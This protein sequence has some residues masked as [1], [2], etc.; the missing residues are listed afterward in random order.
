MNRLPNLTGK[1][2]LVVGAVSCDISAIPADYVIAASGGIKNAPRADMLVSIDNSMRHVP[3]ADADFTGLRVIGIPS[4]DPAHLY[5]PL[6]YEEVRLD[7]RTVVHVRNNALSAIRLAAQCGA[8]KIMLAGFDLAA[9]DSYNAVV[10]F[11][12]VMVTA[13][14]ALIAEMSARGVTVEYFMAPAPTKRSKTWPMST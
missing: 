7:E 3:G 6:P 13:M 2:V 10:G 11:G 9:Y 1:T 12:G 8:T 4:E 14:P 5:I